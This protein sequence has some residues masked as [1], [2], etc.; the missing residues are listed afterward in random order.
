MLSLFVLVTCT[1]DR[2]G[3]WGRERKRREV[4]GKEG[5]EV[6]T[7]RNRERIQTDRIVSDRITALT[8]GKDGKRPEWPV[9]QWGEA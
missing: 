3:V 7:K 4:K 8:E 1:I 2:K 6:A 9:D 5:E